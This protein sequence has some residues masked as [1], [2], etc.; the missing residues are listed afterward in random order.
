MQLTA[1]R[2][3]ADAEGVRQ[4]NCSVQFHVP[5]RPVIT[6]ETGAMDFHWAVLF[7]RAEG[8]IGQNSPTVQFEARVT[9][10]VSWRVTT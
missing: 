9:Q 1:L 3:A 5:P 10:V 7:L 2:A 6:G 4:I 8:D